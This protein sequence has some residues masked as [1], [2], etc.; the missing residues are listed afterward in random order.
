MQKKKRLDKEKGVWAS[1]GGTLGAVNIW[2]KLMVDKGSFSKPCLS[3]L[4]LVPSPSLA[5][6]ILLSFLV[7]ERGYLHKQNLSPAFR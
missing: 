4:T 7:R 2:V 3:R 6:R 5:I 1:G